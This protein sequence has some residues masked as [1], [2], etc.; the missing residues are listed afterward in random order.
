ML[1]TAF[2]CPD[3]WAFEIRQLANSTYGNIYG[4]HLDYHLRE[5]YLLSTI[6]LRKLIQENAL[7]V[8]FHHEK[9][10]NQKQDNMENKA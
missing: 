5:S 6:L 10:I 1:V 4:L 8:F 9:Q 3:I 2:R 7:S